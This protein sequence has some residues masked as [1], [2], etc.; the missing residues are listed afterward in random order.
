M[1]EHESEKGNNKGKKEEEHLKGEYKPEFT[2]LSVTQSTKLKDKKEKH[3]ERHKEEPKPNSNKENLTNKLREN[4]WIA[5][6]IILGGIIIFLLS[7]SFGGFTGQV[8]EN[9]ATENLN[10]FLSTQATGAEITQI[11]SY[12]NYLF[13]ADIL[14]QGQNIPLYITK[15][16]KYIVQGLTPLGTPEPLEPTSS[17]IPKSN[18]PVV[19]LFIWAY[20]PYGVQ[21]QGPLAEVASLLGNSADF[22]AVLYYDGHGAF[23]TQQNKIQSCIQ[24][25]APEKY[26]A[27]ATGFVDNIY[28][29]CGATKDIDCD[30]TESVKL[31]NSLGINSNEVLSCISS[32]GETL[33]KE[34]SDRATELGVTGSPTL[35][36]NGV[37]ANPASR[38]ADAFKIAVCEGFNNLPEA[39]STTLDDSTTTAA[40]NC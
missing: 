24:E 31:M 4:P 19:E 33:I 11:E 18:N 38:T 2:P 22:K 30:K 3:Q 40:G 26:W 16:G 28:P 9:Q 13:L 1:E 14:F 39:C 29:K 20:C 5:S 27:Y 10:N 17:D 34:A 32:I 6:T 7:T 25:V 35:V 23:E 15:D 37:K 12:N 36:I 21:A 8:T